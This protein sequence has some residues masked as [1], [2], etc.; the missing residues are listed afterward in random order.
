MLNQFLAAN[1]GLLNE[2][3]AFLLRYKGLV[4]F[5]NKV[6]WLQQRIHADRTL[7]ARFAVGRL[8]EGRAPLRR[9]PFNNA[10]ALSPPTTDGLQ[11][12]APH[13]HCRQP[14]DAAAVVAVCCGR[15]G[16]SASLLGRAGN[17]LCRRGR[18]VLPTVRLPAYTFKRFPRVTTGMC[19]GPVREFSAILAEAIVS[20]KYGLFTVRDVGHAG[21]GVST[22]ASPLTLL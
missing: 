9:L 4:N 1:I 19:L 16:R 17:H 14:R 18:Y 8:W 20:E 2:S 3:F 5:E 11:C 6:A 10:C 22:L 13:P 7:K 15:H 12:H 21:T